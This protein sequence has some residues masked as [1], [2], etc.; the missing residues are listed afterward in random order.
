MKREYIIEE[1][2]K[3]LGAI[4]A[5]Y[6]PITGEGSTSIERKAVEIEGFPLERMYL[7]LTMLNEPFVQQLTEYGATGYLNEMS[8]IE[9]NDRNIIKLWLEFCLKRIEHDFEYWARSMTV[10]ADK[11]KGRDTAFTLN[12]PQRIYLKAMEELRIAQKPID[13][14]L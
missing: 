11:G 14:I 10:I 3:R 8:G 1:N 5:V 12:R 9:P 4:S 7:P 2:K 6:N 13:I